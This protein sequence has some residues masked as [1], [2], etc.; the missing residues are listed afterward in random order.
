MGDSVLEIKQY[1]I[2]TDGL[3]LKIRL[4]LLMNAE[5]K[6]CD[7]CNISAKAATHYRMI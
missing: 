6:Y 1:D 3:R 2:T 5:S 4:N 7:D